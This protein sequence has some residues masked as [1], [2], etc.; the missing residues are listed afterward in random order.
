MQ[1]EE[2]LLEKC[3][4]QIEQK[5]GWGGSQQWTNQD[6]TA[7]SEKI[8]EHT[9]VNLSPT[10]LKRVWGKVKYESLPTVNTLNTLAHYAGY[11]NWRE[12]K[13]KNDNGIANAYPVADSVAT[14]PRPAETTIAKPPAVPIAKFKPNKKTVWVVVF[15]GVLFLGGWAAVR[16]FSKPAGSSLPPTAFSVGSTP[17]AKG[18]PNSVV[19]TYDATA[20]APT[21]SVFIQ[22]S[23][24]ESRRVR[25]QKDKHRHTSVYYQ[26]GYFRAKLVVNNQVVKEHDLFVPSEGWVACVEQKPVPVYFPE[27]QVRRNGMLSL[28]VS[29]IEARHITMQPQPPIVTFRNVQS[30]EDLRSDNF[31]FETEL[32]HDYKQGSAACQFCQIMILLENDVMMFPFSN[33]GCVGELQVQVAEKFADSKTNDLSA[34]GS[35]MSQWTRFRC[36]VRNKRVQLFVN[37]KKAF[38]T[39]FANPPARIVGIHYGF[40]GTGSVN[41]ARLAKATGEV[42]FEESF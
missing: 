39:T 5:T 10:T 30:F 16:T 42:V 24:D 2:T 38:E 19:F 7:L 32:R 36:E 25:V 28:P 34:F 12:F 21:D 8:Y 33:L 15:L 40:R 27:K 29:L 37:D 23:W 18:I 4:Q 9:R 20:A 3:K 22:Q 13:L 14:Q 31:T 6:F 17:L 11:E 35:D 26:P 41:Y 1:T